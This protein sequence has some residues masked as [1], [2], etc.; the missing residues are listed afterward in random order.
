MLVFSGEGHLKERQV[1]RMPSKKILY[2]ETYSAD[3]VVKLLDRKGREMAMRK[4]TLVK[5]KAPNLKVDARNLVVLSLPFRTRE[6]IQQ[7]RKLQKTNEANLRFRDAR[8]LLAADV[9]GGDSS[10]ALR[11]FLTPLHARGQRQLG[12]YVLLAA[13]GQNLDSDHLD[14]MAEHEE[15]PLAQYLALHTS[16]VLRKH[17]SQW[18][19]SSRQW[20]TTGFLQH[21]A[22]SHALFQR[23]QNERVTRGSPAKVKAERDRA[24]KYV[25]DNKGSVFGVV[26]LCLMEDRAGKDQAFHRTLAELWPH[27]RDVPGLT[28]VAP[29]EQARCLWV[30]GQKE[31]ASKHFRELYEKTLRK[32]RLPPIDSDFREALLGDGK[33][34]DPWSDLIRKTAARLVKEKKRFAV[35][36]LAFQCWELEDQP[37]A[38][39]L[40]RTALEG[41]PKGMERL[42]L[43]LAGLGF[44]WETGQLERVDGVLR[45]L[46]A[47]PQ[48]ARRAMLWRL[49]AKLA[50][51][52]DQKARAL[53]CLEKALECDFQD[54]TRIIDL[55]KLRADYG[56]LLA[57]YQ[58]LA[59]AM[60]ALRV[61]PPKDFRARVVRAA[62][63]WRA[64]DREQAAES[65]QL[66]GRIFQKLGDRELS[67]DYLTTPIALK[68]NEAD[69]L[70]GLAQTLVRRGELDLADR[71]FRAAFE[72][73]PTNAQ[74]LWDRASNLRAAGKTVAARKLLR[75]LA[76]GK[77]QPRFQSLRD[78]ARWQLK[79]R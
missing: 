64:L 67:W 9:V 23:W 6:H 16:P 78:Q 60:I 57:H 61:K 12:L 13:C 56:K 55:Q 42:S 53:D 77:W 11:V 45:N 40:L 17:A 44:L 5:A 58:S 63:R 32:N 69:P 28:Y 37:L 21:L 76:E 79:E 51:E 14:V 24:V 26:L 68:P 71:A 65:C 33:G 25:R 2:R 70:V 54:P 46:L 47:N 36:A 34:D 7:V 75:R 52:R 31:E 49:G 43:T 41:A 10:A 27:F 38:N 1:V 8:S 18:A 59:D 50:E 3:G 15:S 62:D 35:L 29:Y 73:E 48:V 74:I 22:I 39:Y 72:A 20:K 66:A 30:S 4:G 19:V